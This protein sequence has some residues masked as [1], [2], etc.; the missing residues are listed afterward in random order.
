M[1]SGEADPGQG[2]IIVPPHPPFRYVAAQLRAR[3][4][5]AK[6]A[7]HFGKSRGAIYRIAKAWVAGG[8]D[9]VERLRWG[10]GRPHK[11]LFLSKAQL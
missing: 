10:R 2:T 7:A 6:V 3:A 9:A 11:N 1:L 5:V 4:T 8:E